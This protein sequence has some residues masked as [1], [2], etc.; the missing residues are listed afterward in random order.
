[1][2]YPCNDESFAIANAIRVVYE[3]ATGRRLNPTLP[4]RFFSIEYFVRRYFNVGFSFRMDINLVDPTTN[5]ARVP[6]QPSHISTE[7]LQFIQNTLP[8]WLTEIEA[9]CAGMNLF[10]RKSNDDN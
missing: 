9:K 6:I 3:F 10:S 1:M 2:K 7:E 8:T 4:K 5:R